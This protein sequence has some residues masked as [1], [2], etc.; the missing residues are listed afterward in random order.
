MRVGYVTLLDK[1]FKCGK[2]RVLLVVF[3][4][5]EPYAC[6]FQEVEPGLVFL[7]GQATSLILGGLT[8]HRLLQVF[9]L[10]C[11]SH[12]VD[13]AFSDTL[14]RGLSAPG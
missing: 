12:P 9:V 13:L 11:R 2:Y 6:V 7:L 14:T 8:V 1:L 5:I 10:K 3:S 4:D